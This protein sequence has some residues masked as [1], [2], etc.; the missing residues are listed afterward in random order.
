MLIVVLDLTKPELLMLEGVDYN[1]AARQ[2]DFLGQM[3]PR[4][5]RGGASKKTALEIGDGAGSSRGQGTRAAGK[6]VARLRLVDEK[7]VDFG[8]LNEEGDTLGTG[9]GVSMVEMSSPSTT[10]ET[11]G[12]AVGNS[13]ESVEVVENDPVV[14][15]S[16]ERAYENLENVGTGTDGGAGGDIAG[17]SS[18]EGDVLRDSGVQA[19]IRAQLESIPEG[20]EVTSP[21]ESY[22]LEEDEVSPP[23]AKLK[24]RKRAV[25]DM[26]KV[27]KR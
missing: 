16:E 4:I 17:D 7:D 5:S 11:E 18:E 24:K 19:V 20:V 22:S 10:E 13:E 9:A 14:E 12:E 21:S 27:A 1:E 26:R 25:S 23:G 6:G 15:A 3:P 2:L 8:A